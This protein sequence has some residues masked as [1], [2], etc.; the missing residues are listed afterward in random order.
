MIEPDMVSLDTRPMT[1]IK[2]ENC[3]T[4]EISPDVMNTLERRRFVSDASRRKTKE[5]GHLRIE[6]GEHYIEI[7]AYEEALQAGE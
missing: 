4:Y 7:A 1:R 6:S 2:C 3:K 5:G